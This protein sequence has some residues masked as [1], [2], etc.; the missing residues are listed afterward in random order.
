M[1]P[2]KGRVIL[3][4]SYESAK[5]VGIITRVWSDTCVNVAGWDEGNTPVALTSLTYLE[6]GAEAAP[7]AGTWSWPPRVGP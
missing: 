1:K 4:V 6:S 7:M 3:F 5:C 2:S